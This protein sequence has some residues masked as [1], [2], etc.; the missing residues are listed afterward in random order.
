M[1]FINSV[2]RNRTIISFSSNKDSSYTFEFG[3]FLTFT[4]KNKKSCSFIL[5]PRLWIKFFGKEYR[6]TSN[7]QM[8]VEFKCEWHWIGDSGVIPF[9]RPDEIIKIDLKIWI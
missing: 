1:Y 7:V 8:K 9:C 4:G 2:Y 3:K 6:L 5:Y